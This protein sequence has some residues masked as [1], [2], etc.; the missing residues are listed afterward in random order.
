MFIITT[1]K[2]FE[3]WFSSAILPVVNRESGGYTKEAL[4]WCYQAAWSA[5]Q[6]RDDGAPFVVLPPSATEQ[7]VM[8]FFRGGYDVVINRPIPTPPA[9]NSEEKKDA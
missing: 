2:K 8:H 6:P 9:Q 1:K 5:A 7:E 3:A 4:E